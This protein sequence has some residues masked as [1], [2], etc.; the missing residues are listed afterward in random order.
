MD[1]GRNRFWQPSSTSPPQ[2]QGNFAADYAPHGVYR[3]KGDDD[4]IGI[5]VTSDDEWRSLCAV[6]PSLAD[7]AGLDFRARKERAR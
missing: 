3:C 2:P 5:A 1:H 7:H 4:W 6:V